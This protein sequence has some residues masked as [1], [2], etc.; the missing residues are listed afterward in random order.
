[1]TAAAERRRVAWGYEKDTPV[2]CNCSGYRKARIDT[3]AQK[4][5][6]LTAPSCAKGGFTVSANACC[7]KW[8]SRTG[9]RLLVQDARRSTPAG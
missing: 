3:K 4:G 7:D 8:S 5:Q 9:E 1:M 6:Q 2:C